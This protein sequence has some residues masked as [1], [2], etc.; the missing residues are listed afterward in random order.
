MHECYLDL[1]INTGKKQKSFMRQK[2]TWTRF[3]LNK[4]YFN[5]IR[6]VKKNLSEIHNETF[7]G[8]MPCWDLL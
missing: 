3:Y 7:M 5:V 8:K 2:K 4:N 6:Y 1:D